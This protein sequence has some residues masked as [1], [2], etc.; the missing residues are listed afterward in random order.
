MLAVPAPVTVV[1]LV[2]V[3]SAA[4]NLTL[5]SPGVQP[6]FEP[7]LAILVAVFALASRAD[8][9]RL[10]AGTAVAGGLFAAGEIR[11]SWRARAPATCSPP[12]C[13][14]S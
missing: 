3:A 4:W 11:G 10:R 2:T 14:S 12:C 7:W 6:P 5:F 1:I 9:R 13:S 8:G